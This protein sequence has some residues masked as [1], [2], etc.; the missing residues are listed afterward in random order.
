[1]GLLAVS[2]GA[3]ASDGRVVTFSAND[4]YSFN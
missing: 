3:G 4:R 1:M 2:M